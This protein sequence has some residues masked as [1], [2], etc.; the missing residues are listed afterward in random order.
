M[1]AKN[2]FIRDSRLESRGGTNLSINRLI[3]SFQLIEISREKIILSI[4]WNINKA[5][6]FCP[7][8]HGLFQGGLFFKI[9]ENMFIGADIDIK[10]FGWIDNTKKG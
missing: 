2:D 10:M 1:L 3:E 8:F 6:Y 4:N 7:T 9:I 5:A